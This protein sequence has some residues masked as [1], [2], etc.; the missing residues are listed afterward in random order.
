MEFFLG[1]LFS[2]VVG[3]GVYYF[4][5]KNPPPRPHRVSVSQSKYYST[6][7]FL[8]VPDISI[9]EKLNT[10]SFSHE[11]KHNVKIVFHDA[12]AYWIVENTFFVADVVDGVIDQSTQKKVD[13]ISADRVELE[14]LSSIVDILTEGDGNDRSNPGNKRI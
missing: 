9:P 4:V 1:S 8:V 7:K 13:T 3:L 6:I 5:L 14:K 10:Q 12:F 2:V 11:A